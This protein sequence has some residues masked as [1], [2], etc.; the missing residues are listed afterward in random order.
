MMPQLKT[1]TIVAVLD[2]LAEN[3]DEQILCNL[4]KQS[5]N[6]RAYSLIRPET[7]K[8]LE[9]ERVQGTI[10]SGK[11]LVKVLD[12]LAN[13]GKT[14]WIIKIIH[15]LPEITHSIQKYLKAQTLQVIQK[16]TNTTTTHL[17]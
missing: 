6:I 15:E 9:S 8:Y 3:K 11:T 16:I 4:Y 1:R 17:T 10:I 12:V 7:Q 2:I 5:G 13:I 14:K